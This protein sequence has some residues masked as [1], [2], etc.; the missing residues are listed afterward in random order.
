MKKNLLT[1]LLA[2]FAIATTAQAQ[3]YVPG[4]RVSTIQENT[5]Y[6]IFNT[7]YTPGDY[8]DRWGF[9]YFDGSVKTYSGAVPESFTTSDANYLF[10][11]TNNGDDTYTLNS[12]GQDSEVGNTFTLTPWMNAED[13]GDA[14]VRNDDGTFTPNDEISEADKVWT[15]HNGDAYWNGNNWYGIGT[16]SFA[17]WSDAHPYAIYTAIEKNQTEVTRCWMTTLT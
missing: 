15:I 17:L 10:T 16:N 4:E 7:A 12:V 13:K 9:V 11:F 14:Q 5:K 1:L 2:F 6:F 8:S 3:V